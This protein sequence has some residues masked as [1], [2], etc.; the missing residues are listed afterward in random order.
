MEELEVTL[1]AGDSFVLSQ[2]RLSNLK[3]PIG[4][5]RKLGTCSPSQFVVTAN[6]RVRVGI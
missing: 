6:I 3:D 4:P 2:S 1:M 5:L